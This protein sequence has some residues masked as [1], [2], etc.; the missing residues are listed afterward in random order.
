MVFI[1]IY[2][3]FLCIKAYVTLPLRTILGNPTH[4]WNFHHSLYS[5]WI[6][7]TCAIYVI[8][9]CFMRFPFLDVCGCP[10]TVV[11]IRDV[12]LELFVGWNFCR[13]RF[14]TLMRIPRNLRAEEFTLHLSFSIFT[15]LMHGVSILYISKWY[16]PNSKIMKVLLRNRHIADTSVIYIERRPNKIHV[17]KNV[18]GNPKACVAKFHTKWFLFS[19]WS[20]WWRSGN[21]ANFVII[22][23]KK[24]YPNYKNIF[25]HFLK[26]S[27]INRCKYKRF[28]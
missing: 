22:F 19:D 17:K 16:I 18:R 28:H 21:L 3:R 8:H 10:L 4:A 5:T 12:G 14:T 25:L 11:S 7:Y 27:I 24:M 15:V 9:K 26:F 23:E 20:H 13:L 6:R 1:K 2:K